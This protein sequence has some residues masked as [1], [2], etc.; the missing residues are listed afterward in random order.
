[1]Q[2]S[3]FWRLSRS[4]GERLVFGGL[5]IFTN[6]NKGQDLTR[7]RA[8]IHL[9]YRFIRRGSRKVTF[10]YLINHRSLPHRHVPKLRNAV[11]RRYREWTTSSRL[12]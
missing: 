10:G 6:A 2:P 1:M 12:Q 7:N 5:Q 11:S 4:S 3:T 9:R 8:R